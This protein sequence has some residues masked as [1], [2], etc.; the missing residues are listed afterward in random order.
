[1]DKLAGMEMF[2]RVVEAGSFAAAAEASGVSP[3]MAAKHIRTIED[4]LGARLLHRTTRRQHL[5]EVGRLYYERC[6]KALADV[7]A[8]EST[9]LELHASPRG[10]LRVIA[11]VNF[12][13][14][15]LV[16]A[17]TEYMD[18]YPE[19]RV[20]L[21]L[22]DGVAALVDDGYEL[23]I[24]IGDDVR[25]ELVARPLQPYQRRLAA[26]PAYLAKHGV[27]THPRE[28]GEHACLGLSYWRTGRWRLV[29]P[30]GETYEATFNGRFTSNQG[31]A[32]RVAAVCGAGIVLQPEPL[33]AEALAD[34][35]LLPVL[36]DWSYKPTPMFL[37]YAP[38]RRPSAK[39]RSAIDFLLDRLGDR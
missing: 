4:R 25:G 27:P 21:T 14:H 36:P 39:L 26:S 33:L 32:L 3:T 2:V 19:V 30:D 23:G 13:T 24:H 18:R 22:D 8:A 20:D 5:T 35:R 6:K 15:S 7:E 10:T 12:G 16:P 37:V 9:A 38:D 17:L 11:P 28:L 31:N 34:G 29:G 1:M